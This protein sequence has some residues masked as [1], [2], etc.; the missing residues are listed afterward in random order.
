MGKFQRVIPSDVNVIGIKSADIKALN[1][2]CGSTKCNDGL[3]CFSRYMK[4]AEKKYHKKG[5]CYNCGHDSIDW[6]RIHKNDVNDAKYIFD[7]LNKEL[8]RKVFDTI[9]IEKEA[10]QSAKKL[11][12]EELKANAKKT[13]STRIKKFNSFIDNRQTPLGKEDIVNYAQHATGTCCR[14]CLETWHNIPKEQE[15]NEVQLN[16]C[17]DLVMLYVDEKLKNTERK[18]S[19]IPTFE[20]TKK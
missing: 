10:I 17:V 7:S 2:K 20:A 8:M 4:S 18:V 3:H 15:L 12:R 5:V 14:K 1:I 11:S 13:L 6:N 9:E 19:E 16:F